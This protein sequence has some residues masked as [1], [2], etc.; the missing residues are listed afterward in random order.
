MLVAL[1]TAKQ[2]LHHPH[3]LAS[4]L[5]VPLTSAPGLG[6]Q[7]RFGGGG[8]VFPVATYY[9]ANGEGVGRWQAATMDRNAEILSWLPGMYDLDS[10]SLIQ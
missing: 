4:A 6:F 7:I 9:P 10:M 2:A 1:P 3:S 8:A 5:G